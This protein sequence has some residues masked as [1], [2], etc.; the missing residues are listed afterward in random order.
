VAKIGCCARTVFV[1][2]GTPDTV[3]PFPHGE[4]LFA[5]SNEPK[6]FFQMDHF[7]H[8]LSL[9]PPS[10]AVARFLAAPTPPHRS[11]DR[12]IATPGL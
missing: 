6:E 5:A 9:G 11:R 7:G 10:H 4:R 2:H 1:A 12:T 3:V 8:S